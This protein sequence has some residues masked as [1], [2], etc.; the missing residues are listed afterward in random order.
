MEYRTPDY[1]PKPSALRDTV[2]FDA[3]MDRDERRRLVAR[4]ASQKQFVENRRVESDIP[5][6]CPSDD[7]KPHPR[8]EPL[9]YDAW[10]DRDTQRR[11]AVRIASNKQ[12]AENRLIM[13]Y[14]VPEDD[15]RPSALRNPSAYRSWL[16][17]DIER[18]LAARKASNKQIAENRLSI[19]YHVPE[20]DP[21][22]SALRNPS[23]YRAWLDR[24]DQRIIAFEDSN[25]ERGNIEN[26]RVESDT[27]SAS[28]VHDPEPSALRDPSALRAWLDR[29]IE[30]KTVALVVAK[31]KF[32]AEI[33][34]A[35]NGR[36]INARQS[37][38]TANRYKP[39]QSLKVS[40][41]LPPRQAKVQRSSVTS[42]SRKTTV[43]RSVP[44]IHDP[45]GH[46]R[47]ARSRHLA[48][49]QRAYQNA[50]SEKD[51]F[52]EEIKQTDV[53][54][55]TLSDEYVLTA[56]AY[57]SAADFQ[58]VEPTKYVEAQKIVFEE[59]M[60]IGRCKREGGF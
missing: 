60:R 24:D 17:R 52:R 5:P 26:R 43:K 46:V 13:D 3:W 33:R 57:N 56:T 8:W 39:S 49:H 11:L 37:A 44:L 30:R 58:A 38:Y 22:P 1:D 51:T 12:I 10:S 45:N 14:H 19:D 6:R 35:E 53:M 2:A 9:A 47:D 50:E 28:S 42:P 36:N 55:P 25:A 29:D 48:L 20:D 16:D 18:R 31:E 23:A 21:R 32:A 41:R 54:L 4:R 27:N 15:P 7:P 59:A 34:R 40:E